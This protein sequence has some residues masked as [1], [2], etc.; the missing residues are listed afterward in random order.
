MVTCTRHTPLPHHHH[1]Q[2]DR[3]RS[4]GHCKSG[5]MRRGWRTWPSA[6][7]VSSR[8]IASATSAPRRLLRPC[9]RWRRR[10]WVPSCATCPLLLW[11]ACCISCCGWSSRQTGRSGT[12]ACWCVVERGCTHSLTHSLTHSFTHSFTHSLLHSLTPSLTL[13]HSLTHSHT[14]THSLTHSL[15]HSHTRCWCRV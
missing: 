6:S 4:P 7:C 14:H 3:L 9:E 13:T 1:H 15:T 12:A 2:H 8:S 11:S 5:T 10:R